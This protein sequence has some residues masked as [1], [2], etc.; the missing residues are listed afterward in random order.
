RNG[1][2]HPREIL[3]I[4]LVADARI[5]RHDLEISEGGL[6]PA[7][8]RIALNVTLEFEFRVH[9]E[10]V[11][12]AETVHLHGVVDDQLR[13]EKGIDA[14]GIAAH[15]LNRFAH[16]GQVHDGG[17]AGEILQQD[18]RGHKGNF[19]LFAAGLP[20]CERADIFGANGASILAAQQ[21][22]QQNAE[23]EGQ[24]DELSEALLFQLFEALNLKSLRANVQVVSR[25]EGIC[26]GDGHSS[27]P[28]TQWPGFYDNRKLAAARER[29]N[30]KAV[31]IVLISTYELGRQPFGLAS[32]AAWLRG[33]GHAVTCLDL[34]REPLNEQAMREAR[35]IAF[36]VPMHTA[37]RLTLELLEPIH[38]IQPQAHLCAYG[39][40]APLSAESFRS[41]GVN[42]LLGGEFEQSL[43]DLAEHL[44]GRSAAPQI[45]PLDTSVSLARLRFQKPDRA[46]LPPLRS[47]AHLVLPSG[48]HRTAGYTEASRGCKHLCRHCPIVPVY[49]GVFRIVDREVVLAD[50]RQQVAAGAQHITFGDPD[51]FN[52]VGHSVA[53]VEALHREH[54]GL[55][56][57]VTIKVEHL[58]KHADRL[59]ALRETGCAFV[60]TAV[61]SVD[62]HVLGILDK[63]HTRADFISVA[64]LMRGLGLFLVPTF[65]PFTPWTTL[66]DYEDLLATLIPLGLVEHVP[67]VQLTIRLLIPAG[68]RLLE[69]LPLHKAAL[70]PFRQEALSYSWANPDGRVDRLQ[71][72]LEIMV[73]REA[74]GGVSR[75]VIFGK[76]WKLLQRTVTENGDEAAA[77]LPLVPPGTPRATIP[78][79]TEPWYC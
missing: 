34:S 45:H 55:S 4:D 5:G 53:I 64:G 37:T 48:E 10:G 63:G 62:D 76:A 8:E 58:L 19:F 43:V 42:S 49:N 56:Y 1:A 47:Y 40:Y 78:Y 27:R 18:A 57:D 68:S 73:Q 25:S 51:F 41:H 30:G 23:G 75:T 11:H 44:E 71:R 28:F 65:V 33:R 12:I 31:K 35:L 13:G 54:P 14:L 74:K 77:P 61:E 39:L 69:V 6:S 52:G 79:L 70:G 59:S 29:Y 17:D 60:T 21:V 20:A 32:P 7:Q 66:E 22:F 26:R 67:P 50:V 15:F 16:R 36:Y 38:R 24:P 9:A 72:D 46:G 3:D 2:N